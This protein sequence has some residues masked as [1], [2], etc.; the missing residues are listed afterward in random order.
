M[1]T[2]LT[3]TLL[4]V[5][6]AAHAQWVSPHMPDATH[7]Y[8]TAEA[9]RRA[10]ARMPFGQQPEPDELGDEAEDAGASNHGGRGHVAA[11]I[12]RRAEQEADARGLRGGQ[13]EWFV[14][15]YTEGASLPPPTQRQQLRADVSL[16]SAHGLGRVTQRPEAFVKV[17]YSIMRRRTAALIAM[18]ITRQQVAKEQ[19]E[20]DA[21]MASWG[22]VQTA[23]RNGWP[24]R[25]GGRIELARELQGG[26]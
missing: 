26:F 3:V 5:T 14:Q 4:L 22:R 25:V 15:R 13:R 7:W 23:I 19:K 18:G 11:V 20:A 21:A 12:A 6:T 16:V 10:A 17:T 24:R 9:E 8:L 2:L 1:R